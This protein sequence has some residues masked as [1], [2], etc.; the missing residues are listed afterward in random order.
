[1]SFTIFFI[2]LVT[3][4]AAQLAAGILVDADGTLPRRQPE[5]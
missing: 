4:V 3:L 2:A 1:M 5:A